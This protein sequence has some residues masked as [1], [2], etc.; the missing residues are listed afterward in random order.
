MV[1]NNTVKNQSFNSTD[2]GTVFKKNWKAILIRMKDQIKKDNVSIVSAGVAFY[3]FLAL[4]PAVAAIFSIYGLVVDP[5]QVQQQLSQA[6][7]ALPDE[8]YKMVSNILTQTAEKSIEALSW[9]LIISIVLS[10]W[11]S[12]KAASAIFTGV[13]IAYHETDNRNLFLRTGIT[14]LFTLGTIIIGIIAIALVLAFPAFIDKFGLP[15]LLQNIL[16]LI[17]WVFLAAIVY[18]VLR[19]LYKI[20]PDRTNPGFKLVN[21]GAIFATIVWLTGSMLFTLYINNFGSYDKTYGS[22]AAVV[23]LMLWFFLT[24]F[25]IIAGAELNSAIEHQVVAD[26]TPGVEKPP[27]KGGAY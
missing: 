17:R 10:L 15:A 19:I 24:G 6:A 8:A 2:Q 25:I 13:N 12:N 1:P 11:S 14:L 18:I 27:E 22:I 3:F 20:A 7:D 26:K 4:F 21:A 23:I 9:S 16:A 5:A